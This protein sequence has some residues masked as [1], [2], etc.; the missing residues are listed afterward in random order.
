VSIVVTGW[1]IDRA[2]KW[3]L[4]ADYAVPLSDHADF[5]E[6]VECVERVE[7]AAIYCTHG[8]LRFVDLLRQRGYNAHSLTSCR[9]GKV[10]GLCGR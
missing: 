5:D 4:G 9:S 1:A 8:P 3:R 2:W 6:L 7:P 10:L